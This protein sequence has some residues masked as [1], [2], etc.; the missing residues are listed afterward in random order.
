LNYR[1]GISVGAREERF[2]LESRV[3]FIDTSI[4]HAGNFQF[5][6]AEFAAVSKLLREDKLTLLLTSATISEV[7][8]HLEEG[9][10]AAASGMQSLRQKAKIL[11]N[12]PSY[13]QSILFE[14]FQVESVAKE[15]IEL[16]ERF[17]ST[18]NL[19]IVS[20]GLASAE[21]VFEKYFS[22]SPPFSQKK[23]DEFRDAFVLESLK[24]YA[25]EEGVRIHVISE[26]DDMRAFCE[27]E[28]LLVWSNKLGE[29]VD[30]ALHLER[31][32]P[33][34]FADQALSALED[35]VGVH[36][37]NYL[38]EQEFDMVTDYGTNRRMERCDISSLTE[39]ARRL[40]DVGRNYSRYMV[41]Y[42]FVVRSQYLQSSLSD[43]FSELST[44]VQ[45][46]RFIA[47]Y[48]K[49]IEVEVYLEYLEGDLSTVSL[50]D[51][52][53]NLPSG[54]ILWDDEIMQGSVQ[55]IS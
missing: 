15:L 27:N 44:M 5:F 8:R 30:A 6:K 33:A 40:L 55:N 25:V 21:T 13:S 1:L 52:S 34:A 28:P 50:E 23:P 35:E 45:V 46:D 37:E 14:D 3:L 22:K 11:R 36:V 26:D 49:C 7:K 18:K 51:W 47:S 39:I 32:E 9:A 54:D 17:L 53:F 16:F 43:Q 10:K 4:Y 2:A 19:K 41:E 42:E 31:V 48:R 29:Y 20:L 12:L 24:A 38:A